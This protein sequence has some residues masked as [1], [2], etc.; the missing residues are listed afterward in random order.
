MPRRGYSFVAPVRPFSDEA[1]AAYYSETET[2]IIL[3]EIIDDEDEPVKP[4]TEK[5]LPAAPK[6]S[7]FTRSK[8]YK[9]VF[10]VAGVALVLAASFFAARN[11]RAKPT[12]NYS[13]ENVRPKRS[14]NERNLGNA[15][16]ISPDGN[17][18][19]YPGYFGAQGSLWLRQVQTG[20]VARLTPV[21]NA[22]FRA[23]EFSPDGNWVY[24]IINHTDEPTESAG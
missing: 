24:Y 8:I 6:Q 22:Q 5:V 20:S 7:F 10:A 4:E 3:E 16:P 14:I 13:V 21:M 11:Y 9:I 17:Y 12:L 18:L 23:Y 19:V 1:E 15:A 2:E